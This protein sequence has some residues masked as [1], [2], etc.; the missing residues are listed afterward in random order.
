MLPTMGLLL[1]SAGDTASAGGLLA[2][3]G[4]FFL[5]MMAIA[6][7]FIIAM[8]KVFTKA[9]Q[10]GWAALVPIYNAYILVKIAG[11]P[12]WWLV[13][14]FIPLANFVVV[15]LLSIAIAKAFGRSGA[16]G[17]FMLFLLAGI[18]YLILGF[19]SDRYMGTAAAAATA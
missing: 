17:F 8:W 6:V 4:T 11:K 7:V 14:F 12:A 5:V 9:G 15:I 13:M 3:G 1:Q 10:P 16:F 18:G 2:L 19:G